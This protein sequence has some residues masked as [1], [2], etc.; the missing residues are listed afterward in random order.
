MLLLFAMGTGSVGWMLAIGAAMAV[1]KN[2]A[3]GRR[4][5]RP[6]GVLLLGWAG[7]IAAFNLSA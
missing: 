5:A 7:A 3:W 6:F 4:A 2:T 1:E